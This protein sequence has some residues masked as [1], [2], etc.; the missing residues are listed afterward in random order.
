M[1]SSASATV[2]AG[3]EQRKILPRVLN[4]RRIKIWNGRPRHSCRYYRKRR[5]P[6][7]HVFSVHATFTPINDFVA[8]QTGQRKDR[9]GIGEIAG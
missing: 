9:K 1:H 8:G 5:T 4:N 3:I 6:R 7:A 2:L